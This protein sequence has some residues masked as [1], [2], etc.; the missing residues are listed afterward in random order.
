MVKSSVL[1]EY[2][3]V[4][5]AYHQWFWGW[6]RGDKSHLEFA[7]ELSTQVDRWCTAAEV[8]SYD[9]L[10]DLMILKQFKN[11]TTY[12][13]ERKVM[14][15]AEAAALADDYVLTHA[16]GTWY[17]SSCGAGAHRENF[18]TVGAWS[19]RPERNV[20][21]E[22]RNEQDAREAGKL[23]NYCH[24]KRDCLNAF[25]AKSKTRASVNPKLEMCVGSVPDQL[26][27]SGR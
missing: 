18:S 20:W 9:G 7:C 15:A 22:Q 13:N 11:Y 21:V 16:G 10:R 2:K 27:D 12:I 6:K 24:W 14:T 4:P 1:K 23:C 17:L 26:L 25:K 8:G 5:D 19:S 3:L